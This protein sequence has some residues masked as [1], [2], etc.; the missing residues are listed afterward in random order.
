[1]ALSSVANYLSAPKRIITYRKN[2]GGTGLTAGQ[3]LSLF[4]SGGS[5]LNG[6]LAVGNIT[7]GIVPV[8]GSYNSLNDG[9]NG[10]PYIP[11]TIN[12]TGQITSIRYSDSTQSKYILVDTLFSMG[13]FAFNAN[14]TGIVSPSWASRAPTANDYNDLEI[15]FEA[16]TAFTGI[17]T[18][19]IDVKDRDGAAVS[20]GAGVSLGI[21]PPIRSMI[22]LPNPSSKGISAI[23]KVTC[24]VATAGTFNIHVMR[25][26]WRA[27]VKYATGEYVD[28]YLK[29][30]LPKVY[31]TS[32]LRVL[33]APSGTVAGVQ[34]IEFEV[35]DA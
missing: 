29:L 34:H 11:L 32:A 19:A 26:L 12:S 31:S 27:D 10:Y 22:Q 25:R 17:P 9:S 7:T 16:V 20:G 1:M 3:Y 13:A 8:A 30:G 18:I 35:S 21:A 24:T 28:N 4:D 23:T 14:I 5:P 15:W 33:F 2:S 6:P